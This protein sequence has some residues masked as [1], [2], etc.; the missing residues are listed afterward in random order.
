MPIVNNNK[1]IIK[2]ITKN[3]KKKINKKSRVLTETK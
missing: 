1:E 2:K 3:S